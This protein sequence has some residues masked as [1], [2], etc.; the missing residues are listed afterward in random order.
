MTDAASDCCSDRF[1]LNSDCE[2][3]DF[4]D[5][6]ED[7]ES[8]DDQAPS[9]ALILKNS[10]FTLDNRFSPASARSS[11]ASAIL[12]VLKA[13]AAVL[14]LIIAGAMVKHR[15]CAIIQVS[16]RTADDVL[17]VRVRESKSVGDLKW[18]IQSADADQDLE[19]WELMVDQHE[20]RDSDS[21][22][23]V[24]GR[25]LVLHKLMR[26]QVEGSRH[27]LCQIRVKTHKFSCASVCPDCSTAGSS[28]TQCTRSAKWPWLS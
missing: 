7:P 28:R 3:D 2:S 18:N 23:L 5:L 19:L 21:L 20:L 8:V 17:H 15:S 1:V 22:R 24:K 11:Q 13:A 10:A 14:F 6:I 26:I 25:E 9:T 27:N 16:V 4:A 12:Q